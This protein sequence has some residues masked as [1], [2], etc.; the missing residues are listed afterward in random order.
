MA[1]K[2]NAR[3]FSVPENCHRKLPAGEV[4]FDE[5][6]FPVVIENV[7]YLSRKF[8]T[9]RDERRIEY[10]L[11]GALMKGLHNRRKPRRQALNFPGFG[12]Y[13]EFRVRDI[14]VRKDFLRAGFIEANCEGQRIGTRI[15]N[16]EHFENCGHLSL[17]GDAIKPFGDVEHHFRTPVDK[18]VVE[19][20][21]G[22]DESHI[23][24]F[25]KR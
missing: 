1:T 22:F 2:K 9:I 5:S 20:G 16:P 7:Q 18:L 24:D 15:R 14:I 12:N 23:V 13:A 25:S 8:E 3:L 21:V 4:F 11:A 19:P 6:R 10:S 17:T